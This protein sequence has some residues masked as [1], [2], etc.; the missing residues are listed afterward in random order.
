MLWKLILLVTKDE[1][2]S[3]LKLVLSV[4]VLSISVSCTRQKTES[5]TPARSQPGV[6]QARH[7]V[8]VVKASSPETEIARNQTGDAL[9]QLKIEKGYHVN[10]NPPTFPY[11]KATEFDL[12][13]HR[14]YGELYRLSR[15]N[16][17]KLSLRGKA[18]GGL[19][20]DDEHQ[21]KSQGLTKPR[22]PG[23][24]NLSGKTAG[25]SL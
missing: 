8:D 18:T 20:R 3:K 11:L 17:Q 24:Q 15:S 4:L 21:S 12:A 14:E 22:N 13:Q 2:L 1:S 6:S 10:A 5:N 25:T 19:R 23:K 9:V 16:H 7:S